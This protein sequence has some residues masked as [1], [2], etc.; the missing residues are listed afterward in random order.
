M[1]A[2]NMRLSRSEINDFINQG[3]SSKMSI[4]IFG[5]DPFVPKSLRGDIQMPTQGVG[6][7]TREKPRA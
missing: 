5:S 3:K 6:H 7:I 2:E 4:H 1:L